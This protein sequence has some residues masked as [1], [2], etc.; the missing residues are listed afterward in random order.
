MFATI[1][2]LSAALIAGAFLGAILPIR[3]LSI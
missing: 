2:I 1:L 3:D